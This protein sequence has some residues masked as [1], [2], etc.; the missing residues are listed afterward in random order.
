MKKL[1]LITLCFFLLFTACAEKTD[2]PSS[3]VLLP[4]GSTSNSVP[5]A[6][7]AVDPDAYYPG[8]QYQ[9]LREGTLLAV[10][11]QPQIQLLNLDNHPVKTLTVSDDCLIGEYGMTLSDNLFLVSGGYDYAA[12]DNSGYFS[13]CFVEGR[14]ILANGSIWDYDGNIIKSFERT[15]INISEGNEDQ[16]TMANGQTI[17]QSSPVTLT[18]WINDD[19]I[20]LSGRYMLFFYRISTDT[21]TLADDM[22]YMD[23]WV[24]KSG[25]N[26]QWW[27]VEKIFP[28]DSGCYYFTCKNKE[29]F[30]TVRTVCYADESGS[31]ELFDGQEFES[32]LMVDDLL[33]M[34]DGEYN[35][36]TNWTENTQIRYAETENR[37]LTDFA[38]LK[39][40]MSFHHRVGD[41]LIFSGAGYDMDYRIVSINLQTKEES[42]F[43]PAIENFNQYSLLGA[44]EINGSL[45]YIYSTF[46]GE[47]NYYLHDSAGNTNKKLS[48]TP[49]L[50]TD[51]SHHEPMTHFAERYPLVTNYNAAFNTT[52]IR[53]R[54]LE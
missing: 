48:T 17:E 21:L 36:V 41:L 44:R 28:A 3:H 45:Q 6:V 14:W 46:D 16:P 37:Q 38:V 22:S 24:P 12:P 11:D 5:D 39:G 32:V 2:S 27:G 1:F 7:P 10:I 31:Y 54:P 29:K 15:Q 51:E 23:E 53:V 35:P 20:A 13:A 47:I 49:Y 34:L 42:V 19:L 25:N 18:C 26:P 9:W 8:S 30:D 43:I 33:L 4:S 50:F 52:H 40:S